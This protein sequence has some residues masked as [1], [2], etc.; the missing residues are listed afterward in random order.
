LW[1]SPTCAE[2]KIVWDGA[3]SPLCAHLRCAFAQFS[4]SGYP[5]AAMESVL[6]TTAVANAAGAELPLLVGEIAREQSRIVCRSSDGRQ[7]I[8]S[9]FAGRHARIG[10]EVF[11]A[12]TAGAAAAAEAYIRK[13]QSRRV[14]VYQATVSYAALPKLDQRGEVWVSIEVKNPQLGI[15]KIHVPCTVVR[16]Y[17]FAANQRLGWKCQPSFYHLLQLSKDSKLKELR[18]GYTIRRMELIK[19][20][21]S[22]AEVA[23]LERAYNMLADPDLRAVYD[24]VRS[25]PDAPVPFPYS[26]FGS[27][28]LQGERYHDTETF[29]AA[30]ILAFL[31]DRQRRTIPVRLSKLDYFDDYAIIRD[32]RRGV[33]VIID[34]QLLPIRWDPGWSQWR[35]HISAT[36]E[37]SA[38]FIHTGRYRMRKGEWKL[39]EWDTALPSRTELELP[40]GL[41]DAI[42]DARRTHT[43]FGRFW[44]QVDNLRKHVEQI[45]TE[46]RELRNLCSGLGMPGDFDI[47]QVTWRPD[48]DAYYYDKLN[49]RARNMFVF[50]DEYIFDLERA[51]VAEIP[52]AG[53]ATYVFA[54]PPDLGEWVWD[55]AKTTRRE[56]RLNRNNVAEA[57]GFRGRVMHGKQK[58]EWLRDFQAKVGESSSSLIPNTQSN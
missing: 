1:V 10:D 35:H 43:R 30:R 53:H 32:R 42:I 18:L 15:K 52:K 12:E 40:E 50:R 31:P 6:E 5:Q 3:R 44:R 55:Y 34:H 20:K 2:V 4:A 46:R 25:D 28:V 13:T 39:I 41:E 7:A 26:G 21:A 37:I 47:A 8:L 57:L 14:D 54:K 17:F 56:I 38:E 49:K 33:E 29:Y 19:E 24:E 27:L 51:I 36:V 16:D 11:V 48:Y 23:T 58:S 9:T 45:P 22:N